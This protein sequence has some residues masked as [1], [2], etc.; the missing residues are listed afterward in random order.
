MF[1]DVMDKESR[2]IDNIDLSLQVLTYISKEYIQNNGVP[3]LEKIS[4]EP[5]SYTHLIFLSM[6]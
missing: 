2:W 4:A 3:T 5:V 1:R 6:G